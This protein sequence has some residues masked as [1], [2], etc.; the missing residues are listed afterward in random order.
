MPD[1]KSPLVT[2]RLHEHVAVVSFHNPGRRNTLSN[3]LLE[4]LVQTF[5]SLPR[6][7]VRAA[8]LRGEP[9]SGVWSAGHDLREVAAGSDPLAPTSPLERAF[10]AIHRF[11][12]PV[13]GE[14]GGSVWGGAFELALCCDLIV[15]SPE[16][17]FSITPVNLGLPYNASGIARFVE[18][19]PSNI[20]SE[21]FFTASSL[22]AERAAQLGLVNQVVP[23]E[24][25]G[26]TTLAIAK[27]IASKAPRAVAIVKRQLGMMERTGL[28]GAAQLQRIEA[29]RAEI[30]AGEDLREG[31][32]AFL[33]KRSPRFDG[34]S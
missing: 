24:E 25:L 11:P 26:A 20:V 29:E 34:C 8:I 6:D 14:I 28:L 22:S 31:V 33:A 13:I 32:A 1:T 21:L 17:R 5:Q 18:R 10:D 19:L 12:A 23:A 9:D 3:D 15:T 27:T 4:S 16:V 7:R 2:T 30:L